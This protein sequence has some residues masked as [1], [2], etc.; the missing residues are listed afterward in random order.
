MSIPM[1]VGAI[2]DRRDELIAM[3]ENGKMTGREIAEGLELYARM[4][5]IYDE[6]QE[7]VL[8]GKINHNITVS[9]DGVSIKFPGIDKFAE[10][11]VNHE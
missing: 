4:D 3:A 8:D 7:L 1:R 9:L 2:L 5:D 11:M 10:W 6:I